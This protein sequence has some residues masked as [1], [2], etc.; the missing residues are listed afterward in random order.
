MITMFGKRICLLF[1]GLISIILLIGNY[2]SVMAKEL[3]LTIATHISPAYKDAWP[4]FPSFVDYVNKRGK[5]K[6]FLDFYHSG[7]LLNHKQLLPGLMQGTADMIFHTDA[8]L[9]GT[10]PI[11]GILELPF[12][13]ADPEVTLRKLTI[14]SPLY[15]IINQEL[16]KKNLFMVFTSSPFPEY[17]WTNDRPVKKPSDLQGLR[18]RVAGR[19]G[20]RVLK[21]LGGASVSLRSAE[22][23]EGLK[24]KT[25]DGT[26]CAVPTIPAR[27][28]QDVLRHV[29]L[30]D[31]SSYGLQL[32][33]PLDRWK[34]LPPDV[35][36]LLLDGGKLFE[37]ELIERIKSYHNKHYW[38]L[39]KKAGVEIIKLTPQEQEVFRERVKPVLDWWKGQLPSGVGEKAIQLITE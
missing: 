28:L 10:F 36:E 16:A 4:V 12:M 30:S 18:I 13:Y 9:M 5:G 11:L 33:V 1:V 17:V 8:Y 32:Y 35:R 27:S 15:E 21:T 34:D 29:T 3:K 31:F 6:V 23:Y 20:A 19:I 37:K 38:P 26:L 7:T 25:V 39:I 14:G 2:H 22:I 24:R